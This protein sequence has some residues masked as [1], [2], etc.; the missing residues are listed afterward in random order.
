ML[1]EYT[2][3]DLLNIIDGLCGSFECY[4]AMGA[5]VDDCD[6]WD[7]YDYMMFPRWRKAVELLL[8]SGTRVKDKS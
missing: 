4:V 6:V 5:S 1:N 8:S 2:K 3:Q 7:E